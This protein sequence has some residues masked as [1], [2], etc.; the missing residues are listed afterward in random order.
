MKNVTLLLDDGTEF[1]GK[2]FGYEKPVAG[3]VVF[4][5]AMMGYPES[6]TD[7]SYAGQILTLT[8]PL[9]GNYGVPP[10]SV[11]PN[12]IATFMES[13]RIYASALVVSEYSGDYSHWNAV[14]SLGDW[15]KREEIPGITGIDTRELTK[16]LREH[17]VMMGKIIFDD[18]KDLIPSAQYSGVNYVAQV[19]CKQIV[20]YNQGGNKK[21]VLV[22][23]GVKNNIIRELLSRHL[24]VIRVPWDYDFNTLDFD[25]LFLANGPGD[26]DTCVDTVNN[27]QKFLASDIVRPCMGICM[28]NQLLSKAA[29]AS[30]YKL[31]YGH[32]SHNQPVRLV[33]SNKCYITSQNHGYCVDNQT[34]PKE[35]KPL[36]I[37]MNDGSNEGV[38]HESR[39][40]F[41]VQF[42][43]EASS[44]PIDTEFLFDDFVKMLN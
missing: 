34:L 17:G 12:G 2:S 42:H 36:F 8:Y 14:E 1:H 10:F 20:R 9:V 28:G 15:L 39:P 3:E 30:I 6:L 11:A 5:T 35:W 7:P 24:E 43:P 19:S 22:D 23:C 13:D 41:S 25:A 18:Q 31:K 37:N 16:I 29:G 38:K 27:I 44:G 26:P 40:W 21:V 4:N 33:G 32:R